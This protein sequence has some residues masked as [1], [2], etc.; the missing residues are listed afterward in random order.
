MPY[1]TKIAAK[2]LFKYEFPPVNEVF[3]TIKSIDNST[4]ARILQR[5]ESHL[6]L[7]EIVIK[8]KKE[9]PALPIFTIHDSILL[10][11]AVP[12]YISNIASDCI[13]KG[14]GHRPCL[15]GKDTIKL[16]SP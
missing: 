8:I 1:E 9:K 16:G 15:K 12:Q 6:F 4:L 7:D 13:E 11:R 2:Q 10:P 14:I 5:V 3:Q